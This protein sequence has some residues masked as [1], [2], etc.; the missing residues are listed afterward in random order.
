MMQD[1]FS[2]DLAAAQAAGDAQARASRK[3]VRVFAEM[4]LALGSD[5]IKIAG[6]AHDAELAEAKGLAAARWNQLLEL[7][8][9][10]PREEA[11]LATMERGR[12]PDP[13]DEFTGPEVLAKKD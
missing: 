5:C 12:V 7:E 11:R 3:D 1:A 13:A 8:A 4:F 6:T 10:I 9:Q 2:R